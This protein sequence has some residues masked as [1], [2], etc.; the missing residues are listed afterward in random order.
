MK[1][2]YIYFLTKSASIG[3]FNKARQQAKSLNKLQN[4]NLEII[5]LNTSKNCQDDKIKYINIR[6]NRKFPLIFY[7]Y[8]FRKYTLIEKSIEDLNKYDFLILRYPG[9][10]RS[11][12]KFCQKY[13]VI[14]EFHSD[15][16]SELQL[17]INSKAYFHRKLIWFIRLQLE[18]KHL[19]KILERCRGIITNS[20]E[21]RKF[22]IKNFELEIPIINISNGVDVSSVKQTGF[23]RFTGKELD[24]VFVGS[25]PDLWHGLDRLINAI[26]NYE[27][28]NENLVIRFH[29]VGKI[30][31]RDL[32]VDDN[33]LNHVFF[34]GPK[35]GRQLDELMCNMHLAVGPLA[36]FRKR[37]NAT[38]SIKIP[39]YIARGIPF[40]LSY[41]DEGLNF[42][43][44]NRSFFL[45]FPND[46]SLINI[47]KVID[48]VIEMNKKRKEIIKY[49]REYAIKHLDWSIKMRQ[50]LDFVNHLH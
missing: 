14:L 24:I 6:Q 30:N 50:Y 8:L 16:F 43:K 35:F 38:S 7:D 1:I 22:F 11:A 9:S 45:I 49:T 2:T 15:I 18:K 25:R 34:C 26:E 13:N 32:K 27:K 44:R 4:N 42:V 29:L 37:L 48:F 46:N 5:V 33:N 21:L 31:E 3:V 17:K 19:R 41:Y 36:L 39:E 23:K 10:D 28:E 40:I 47:H 20:N 12:I